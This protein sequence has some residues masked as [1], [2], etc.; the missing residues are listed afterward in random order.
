MTAKTD[1]S[2]P[3][4]DDAIVATSYPH[5]DRWLCELAPRVSKNWNGRANSLG[6]NVVRLRQGVIAGRSA[7]RRRTFES[8]ATLLM[9]GPSPLPP[10]HL[11]P[12][13]LRMAA[14][15]RGSEPGPTAVSVGS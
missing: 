2:I 5:L 4:L 6:D 11:P 1:H 15:S 8:S 7:A 10:P 9:P 3:M 12:R 14:S 13:S